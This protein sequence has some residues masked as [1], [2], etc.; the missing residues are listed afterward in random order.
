[1]GVAADDDVIVDDDAEVVPGFGDPLGDRDIRA[2]RLGA[3]AGVVVDEDQ[4]SRA[5]VQPLADDL[6]RIDRA[7]VDGPVVNDHVGD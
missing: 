7:F 6:A 4:R 5:D 3:A 1:M 2:A